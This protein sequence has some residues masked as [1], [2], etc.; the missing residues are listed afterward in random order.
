MTHKY[1]EKPDG[2]PPPG[3]STS[4]PATESSI[5]ESVDHLEEQVGGGRYVSPPCEQT[6]TRLRTHIK[7]T[8]R[9]VGLVKEASMRRRAMPVDEKSTEGDGHT[10]TGGSLSNEARGQSVPS[11][12]PAC[13]PSG[14]PQFQPAVPLQDLF[15]DPPIAPPQEHRRGL[16]QPPPPSHLQPRQH[17]VPP[18][19]FI[20]APPN[21]LQPPQHSVP[22]PSFI[23]AAPRA[24]SGTPGHPPQ[25]NVIT[26]PT[27]AEQNVY[28]FNGDTYDFSGMDYGTFGSSETQLTIPATRVIPPTPVGLQDHVMETDTVMDEAAEADSGHLDSAVKGRKHDTTNTT[29]QQGFLKLERVISEISRSTSL[30]SQQIISLWNKSNTRVVNNINHWNAYSSYFKTNFKQEISRLGHEAPGTPSE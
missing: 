19:T 18:P 7:P 2:S 10:Q 5:G 1:S 26:K 28:D 15:Y 4:S 30:P 25:P 23:P 29:L 3:Y 13:M 14:S 20:P 11:P 12:A 24:R 22:P 21:H 8:N 17:S 16:S 9:D 27:F 6:P